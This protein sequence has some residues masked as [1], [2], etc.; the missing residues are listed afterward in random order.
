[1][2]EKPGLLALTFTAS[3]YGHIRS[4]GVHVC[5]SWCTCVCVCPC[6][7]VCCVCVSVCVCVCG[8]K[9][10]SEDAVSDQQGEVLWRKFNKRHGKLLALP[11]EKS[12]MHTCLIWTL[13]SLYLE[14]EP[15]SVTTSM[16]IRAT[17]RSCDGERIDQAC[18]IVRTL[19]FTP[20]AWRQRR[21]DRGYRWIGY[22]EGEG[23]QG[24]PGV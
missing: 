20:L 2:D 6:V 23:L 4:Y 15:D 16:K 12:A 18:V 17:I 21:G 13:R 9:A 14:V 7:C 11:G 19:L 5:R 10:G 8:E 1:M 24:G 22:R 3:S